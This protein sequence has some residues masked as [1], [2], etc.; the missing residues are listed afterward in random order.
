MSLILMV[1]KTSQAG[2]YGRVRCH[3][4]DINTAFKQIFML[5]AGQLNRHVVM[6]EKSP[7]FP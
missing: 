4:H 5:R 3:R 2:L 7:Q 1:A 6:A